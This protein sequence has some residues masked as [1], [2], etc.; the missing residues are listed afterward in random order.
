MR[1]FFWRSL[2]EASGGCRKSGFWVFWNFV[3][4]TF[5]QKII[6]CVLFF[7]FSSI[8]GLNWTPVTR[9]LDI[10][11]H[12]YFE[13][14]FLRKKW[15]LWTRTHIRLDSSLI[16]IGKSANKKIFCGKI[17]GKCY[18]QSPLED[19]HPK[20]LNISRNVLILAK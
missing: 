9:I 17:S 11:S 18:F 6:I 20:K 16:N 7:R 10:K 4:S 19:F 3:D 15:T 1:F 8:F 13:W 12:S 14:R 2:T 5:F